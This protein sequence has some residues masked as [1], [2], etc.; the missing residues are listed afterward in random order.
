MLN[1]SNMVSG[2]LKKLCKHKESQGKP[3][4]RRDGGCFI[5]GTWN[6]WSSE[7]EEEKSRREVGAGFRFWILILTAILS[8]GSEQALPGSG[9]HFKKC[10]VGNR[11]E[12][13]DGFA[14]RVDELA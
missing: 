5:G 11:L 14:I 4:L 2:L 6:G 10:S 8:T 1:E 13:R 7:S 12:G 9:L 3:A